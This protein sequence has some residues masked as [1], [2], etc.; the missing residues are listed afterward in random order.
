MKRTLLALLLCIACGDD[1]TPLDAATPDGGALEDVGA[2]GDASRDSGA[3]SDAA[4]LDAALVDAEPN[5]AMADAGV[6]DASLADVAPD[7]FDA[8]PPID[9]TIYFEVL[10]EFSAEE[11]IRGVALTQPVTLEAQLDVL[12]LRVV[13]EFPGEI[14]LRQRGEGP[15][16][17]GFGDP[18]YRAFGTVASGEYELYVEYYGAT[19]PDAPQ[20]H[21]TAQLATPPRPAESYAAVLG[22]VAEV[23]DTIPSRNYVESRFTVR[24]GHR[25]VAHGIAGLTT[26][27]ILA[28]ADVDVLI[29]GGSVTP[30]HRWGGSGD[31]L[32]P[33]PMY[34][35]L[36]PGDYSLFS[37]N[38]DDETR[39]VAVSVD[40]WELR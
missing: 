22:N 2:E 19:T 32:S 12:E 5:D 31:G 3:E 9:D 35:D 21:F 11:W 27:L 36:P 14:V 17:L 23:L 15:I 40:E 18:V 30:L 25:Y 1:T 16:E 7:V 8:G 13:R 24:P 10:T 4:L 20:D 38:E 6:S 34:L 26:T 29:G 37:V 33:A 28:E 39:G